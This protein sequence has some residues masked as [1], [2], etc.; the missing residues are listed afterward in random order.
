MAPCTRRS[1]STCLVIS[2]SL[3]DSCRDRAAAGWHIVKA[4]EVTSGAALIWRAGTLTVNLSLLAAVGPSLSKVGHVF[5]PIHAGFAPYS[6]PSNKKRDSRTR[7][8][9]IYHLQNRITCLDA[10]VKLP[11]RFSCRVHAA[12]TARLMAFS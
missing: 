10:G 2:S 4:V 11:I 9:V 7:L 6:G 8:F 5:W 12:G 3:P 1:T